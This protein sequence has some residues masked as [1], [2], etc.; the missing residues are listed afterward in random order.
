MRKLIVVLLLACSLKLM[1]QDTLS[2]QDIH[3]AA[4]LLDL[5]F[6]QK[7]IDTMYEGVKENL[8]LYQM[9]HKQSLNNN[10][11]M[12]L[13]QS[14]VL[15][16]MKFNE[17]QDPI[18]WNIPSNVSVPPNQNDLAFYSIPQLASLIKNKK[19]SSV[20]LT[21]FFIDRK[22]QRRAPRHHP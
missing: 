19:I 17:K 14:P 1:A 9:M 16:G 22:S 7:E 18:N 15:P 2:K 3:S 21:R 8:L 11:P 5:Q 12:S 13:W 6:T 10:V 4:K 20:A